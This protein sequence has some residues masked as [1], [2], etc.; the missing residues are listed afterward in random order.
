[1]D[2][3]AV[4]GVFAGALM[5]AGG[6]VGRQRVLEAVEMYAES[7]AAPEVLTVVPVEPPAEVEAT[8]VADPEPV[9]RDTGSHAG[10]DRGKD[11]CPGSVANRGRGA[12]HAS[13]GNAFRRQAG[14]G[15]GIRD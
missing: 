2:E 8:A 14:R 10:S 1:M 6:Q 5:G 15:H 13:R 3:A 12:R 7:P 9:A 4:L 11:A